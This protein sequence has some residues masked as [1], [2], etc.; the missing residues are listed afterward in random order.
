MMR[1]CSFQVNWVSRERASFLFFT[2]VPSFKESNQSKIKVLQKNNNVDFSS[3]KYKTMYI[4]ANK[5]E[6]Q[7]LY[8][9][10]NLFFP[11]EYFF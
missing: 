11:T 9:V 7:K 5:R 1:I 2:K 8:H 10:D 4:T 6:R 3:R